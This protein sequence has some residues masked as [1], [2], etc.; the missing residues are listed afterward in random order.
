MPMTAKSPKTAIEKK[1]VKSEKRRKARENKKDTKKKPE[2]EP[3]PSHLDLDEN[4]KGILRRFFK[5]VSSEQLAIEKGGV[6]MVSCIIQYR[7][8]HGRFSM[9]FANEIRA[10]YL[11]VLDKSVCDVQ[12]IQDCS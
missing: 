10:E 5:G 1:Q 11:G 12:N 8:E 7:N 9:E 3:T 4:V 6:S 2:P